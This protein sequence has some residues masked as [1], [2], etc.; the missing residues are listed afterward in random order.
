MFY[1]EE[2][3]IYVETYKEHTHQNSNVERVCSL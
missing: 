2:N 3:D 1:R